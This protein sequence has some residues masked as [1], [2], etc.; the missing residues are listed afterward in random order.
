M[1]AKREVRPDHA[2]L[3]GQGRVYGWVSFKKNGKGEAA[4]MVSIH[5]KKG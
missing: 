4:I 1:R 2:G 3:A 5:L